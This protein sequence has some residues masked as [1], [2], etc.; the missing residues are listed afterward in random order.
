MRG[1]A[2]R[3]A[4]ALL[5]HAA[6]HPQDADH[7]LVLLDTFGHLYTPQGCGGRRS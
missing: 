5:A 3:F 6:Q 4:K 1:W 2:L 7:A